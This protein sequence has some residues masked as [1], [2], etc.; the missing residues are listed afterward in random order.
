MRAPVQTIRNAKRLRRALSPPEAILWSKLRIRAP[1]QPTFRRQH[2]IGLYVLDFY[3][4]R[5]RLA[6]E[7]DGATHS[8][9]DHLKRDARRD[10]WLEK[11]GIT[12]YR[13][14]AVDVMRH[15]GEVADGVIRLAESLLASAGQSAQE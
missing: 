12:V 3:C 10:E 4:A 1:G 15:A 14:S 6:V 8:I 13:V 7:I 9:R 11:Q 5:A 2:P